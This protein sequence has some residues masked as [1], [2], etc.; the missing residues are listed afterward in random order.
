MRNKVILINLSDVWSIDRIYNVNDTV[1]FDSV[2]YQNIT[3]A[4]S[5]P[6]DLVDWVCVDTKRTNYSFSKFILVHK[7]TANANSNIELNDLAKGFGN[8]GQ[9]WLLARYKNYTTDNNVHN[10]ANYEVLSASG[11]VSI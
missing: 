10:P 2:T 4:N 9:Y 11:L 5:L 3:G 6:N 7:I 1:T 8:D